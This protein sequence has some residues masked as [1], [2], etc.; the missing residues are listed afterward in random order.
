MEIQTKID[1]FVGEE[2]TSI[3]IYDSE[4][5]VRFAS[6]TIKNCDFLQAIA[7][8]GHIESKC[9]LR[10]LDKVGKKHTTTTFKFKMVDNVNYRQSAYEEAKNN[11]PEGWI[12]DNYFASQSSFEFIGKDVYCNAII[13]KWEQYEKR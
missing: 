13:R 3:E 6:I 1:I 5:N 8:H 9:I 2:D 11:C 7:R 10:G 4:A 12:V